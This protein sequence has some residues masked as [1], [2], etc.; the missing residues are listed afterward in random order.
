MNPVASYV[1]P[2]ELLTP[3]EVVEIKGKSF[4]AGVLPIKVSSLPFKNKLRHSN[5]SS[6]NI[7]FVT[8]KNVQFFIYFVS[9]LKNNNY[10]FIHL[11][12]I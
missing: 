12:E 3:G 5:H 8:I 7:F 11:T 6:L 2:L 9:I 1:K 10:C 4:V